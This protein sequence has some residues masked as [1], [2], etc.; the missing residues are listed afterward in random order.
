V[1]RSEN[2]EYR[3]IAL[4]AKALEKMLGNQNRFVN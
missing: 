2:D 1:N 4:Q 3:I